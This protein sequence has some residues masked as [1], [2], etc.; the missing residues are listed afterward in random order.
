LILY[1]S[2][3]IFLL[4]MFAIALSVGFNSAR[5]ATF[6]LILFVGGTGVLTIGVFLI[7]SEV[8]MSHQAICYEVSRV[9]ALKR[10]GEFIEG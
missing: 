5:V 10:Q 8:R 6:A 3:A 4:T 9:I 1:G 2:I 7:S